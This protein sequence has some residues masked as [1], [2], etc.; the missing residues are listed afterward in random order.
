MSSSKIPSITIKTSDYSY[1]AKMNNHSIV[2]VFLGIEENNY[3]Y[4]LPS[5]ES[6]NGYMVR[7]YPHKIVLCLIA[8][9]KEVYHIVFIPNRD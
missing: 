6:Y 4:K 7:R 3:H 2:H 9:I 1:I 5:Q 8:D